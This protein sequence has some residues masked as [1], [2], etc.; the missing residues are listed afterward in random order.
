[1]LQKSLDNSSASID[2]VLTMIFEMHELDHLSTTWRERPEWNYKTVEWTPDLPIRQ[3]SVRFPAFVQLHGDIWLAYEWN[4]HRTARIILH[5]HL[6]ETIARHQSVMMDE[7]T[8]QMR[9]ISSL[10]ELSISIIRNLVDDI[11]STVPQ[12]LGDIDHEGKITESSTRIKMC[13]GIGGYFLLWPIK[14]IKGNTFATTE[15]AV[16]AKSVFER[17]RECTGMKSILGDKSLI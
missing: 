15:Q 3:Q 5:T 7:D 12:S 11:L 9:R 8:W 2:Q 4:Y 10:K 1:M 6:L 17:I 13:F 16:A 14:V